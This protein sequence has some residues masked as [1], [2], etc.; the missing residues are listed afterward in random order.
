MRIR[1]G[2]FFLSLFLRL[3][4]FLRRR[5]DRCIYLYYLSSGI[6]GTELVGQRL[7]LEYLVD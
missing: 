5:G 4:Y 7:F 6:V 2:F 3:V 1:M